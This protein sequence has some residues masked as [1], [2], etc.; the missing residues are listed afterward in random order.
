M[1]GIAAYVCLIHP[2][3]DLEKLAFEKYL[4]ETLVSM[5]SVLE[6]RSSRKMSL[7]CHIFLVSVGFELR[8]REDCLQEVK[9]REPGLSVFK[10]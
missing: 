5:R 3:Y 9:L 10:M 8:L 1:H 2:K 6:K 7:I 4:F